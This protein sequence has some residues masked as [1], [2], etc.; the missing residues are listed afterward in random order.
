MFSVPMLSLHVSLLKMTGENSQW[1]QMP[2]HNSTIFNS[3]SAWLQK[4]TPLPSQDCAAALGVQVQGLL[5]QGLHRRCMWYPCWITGESTTSATAPL[6]TGAAPIALN[7][8]NETEWNYSGT[9]GLGS[10]LEQH[11]PAKEVHNVTGITI[12]HMAGGVGWVTKHHLQGKSS[13]HFEFQLCSLTASPHRHIS[14]APK[15]RMVIRTHLSPANALRAPT[16]VEQELSFSV[17]CSH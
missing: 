4:S 11:P 6:D 15:A 3:C 1:M 12:Q 5:G 9:G 16:P 2:I 17:M 7:S 14:L 8:P 10:L 13:R